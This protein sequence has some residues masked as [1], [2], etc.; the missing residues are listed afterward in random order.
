MRYRYPQ[1][2]EEGEEGAEEG[3]ISFSFSFSLSMSSPCCGGGWV[4]VEPS[5]TIHPLTGGMAWR[6][7][8]AVA[9]IPVSGTC[10]P[11]MA[12]IFTPRTFLVFFSF[13]LAP[14]PSSS[15]FPSP[16]T[17][18]STTTLSK[19]FNAWTLVKASP[20]PFLPARWDFA[21]GVVI[22]GMSRRRESSTSW[23]KWS[24]W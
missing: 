20:S 18:I 19:Q 2:Q 22:M 24:A 15:S 16:L 23:S 8:F 4:L 17:T 12:V 7:S 5:S 3:L 9:R 1:R 13:S 14:F 21:C 6:Y 10:F 11:G